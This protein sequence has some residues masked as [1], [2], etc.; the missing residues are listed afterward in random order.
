[1]SLLNKLH[2]DKLLNFIPLVDFLI[3]LTLSG[4]TRISNAK[5][6]LAKPNSID[7]SKDAWLGTMEKIAF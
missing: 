4:C 7:I 3:S 6:T 1:L 2:K 5:K